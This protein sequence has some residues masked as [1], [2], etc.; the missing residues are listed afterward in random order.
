M[1]KLS[2]LILSLVLFVV[3]VLASCKTQNIQYVKIKS[4]EDSLSFFS[5]SEAEHVIRP[6]DKLNLSIHD[7]DDL[8]I[9]SVY[10]IYNAN[11]VYSRWV[12]VDPKGM[13]AL[14]RLG[15]TPL[16]GLTISEAQDTLTAMYGKWIV[17]PVVRLRILNRQV[18][19]LGEVKS[20][21][22]LNLEKEQNTLAETIARSGD[23][24]F[25]ADKRKVKVVRMVNDTLKCLTIDLTDPKQA[26]L[27][28]LSVKPGDIVYVPS[29]RG[30]VWDK[31]SG[32]I[33]TITGVVTTLAIISQL[34]K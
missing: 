20:P 3:T 16:A 31:R 9:G 2:Y 1:K 10:G 26:E 13:A 7:H 21:G 24:E 11:E 27:L 8:S 4:S 30:K 5:Q 25:Y 32:S 17:N 12:L 34:F 18:S 15:Q 6:D 28:K 22:I 33:L 19:I 29:R 23:M 14:P